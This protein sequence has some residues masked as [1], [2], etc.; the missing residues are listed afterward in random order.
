MQT[1]LTVSVGESPATARPVFVSGD[2]DVARV[3]VTAI[4]DRIAGAPETPAGG[5]VLPLPLRS[6]PR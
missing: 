2:Q 4:M 6:A 3:V 5:N 1:F